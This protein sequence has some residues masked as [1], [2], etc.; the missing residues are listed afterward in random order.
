MSVDEQSKILKTR[1]PTSGRRPQAGKPTAKPGRHKA[2]DGGA[3][4]GARPGPGG[5]K[6][7]QRFSGRGARPIDDDG[8]TT[9]RKR[10]TRPGTKPGAGGRQ[11]YD[12]TSA[13]GKGPRSTTEGQRTTRGRRRDTTRDEDRAMSPVREKKHIR[14]AEFTET[15]RI[16]KAMAR[17]GLCSRREAERWVEAGRVSVNGTKLETPATDVGP[18][19]KVLIDGH[20]LPA[21]EPSRIWRYHKP[22]GLLTTHR[23]E[24]KYTK[25]GILAPDDRQT[26]FETL[27]ADM[28]RVISI[29]RL[30]YNTEGLLLLT[31]DG[32]L[33][34]YL[35]LPKTGWL[36]RYRV[37]VNGSI[38]QEQLNTLTEGVTV[39]GVHYGP[40]TA[41]LDS[42]QGANAWLTV[43]IREGK[44]REVRKIMEHLGL[45]VNRLIRISFGPFQL[46]DL[47]PGDVE[48]VKPRALREQLSRQVADELGLIDEPEDDVLSKPNARPPRRGP[49][50]NV[51]GDKPAAKKP[52]RGRTGSKKSSHKKSDTK[53]PSR[54]R[55][56]T[57]GKPKPRAKSGGPKRGGRA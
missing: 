52:T 40:I 48:A 53:K 8:E 13:P 2:S 27:P 56:T 44:N 22:K 41:T 12:P 49:N 9:Y 32:A 17:S 57:P 33:A 18:G 34:R 31:N 54:T 19:D 7:N 43:A 35:E 25:E 47:K 6:A 39:D 14:P 10:G 45:V 21:A 50:R 28:G 20:P 11:R 46:L 36:R 15:M 5:G 38:T 42:T 23:N 4:Q 3:R 1:K 51:A 30:D 16:A 55:V 29:G 37:R 26:V 24:Q